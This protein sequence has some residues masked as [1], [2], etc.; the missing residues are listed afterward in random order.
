[1][2]EIA[3]VPR[4]LWARRLLLRASWQKKSISGRN[5]RATNEASF[6][7]SNGDV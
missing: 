3:A 1:M 7:V 6:P 5:A 4:A 2:E